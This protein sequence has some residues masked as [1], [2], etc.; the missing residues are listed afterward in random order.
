MTR[1]EFITRL[2][3]G[4][5]GLDPDYIRDVMADYETHFEDGEKSGRSE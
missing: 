1:N 3:Q 4:L 5:V 2:R